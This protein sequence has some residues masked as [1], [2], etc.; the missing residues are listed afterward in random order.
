[1]YLVP[2]EIIENKILLIRGQKIMIDKDLA[3]LYH[4]KTKVLNQAVK[5]NLSRFPKDFMFK[6]T[7]KEKAEVVTNCDHLKELKYSYQKPY[8]FT[9]YGALM[10][11]NILNTTIAVKV[12]IQIVRT[13]VKLRKM[14]SSNKEIK[15]KIEELES[16]YDHQFKVVF[17]VI[18]KLLEPETKPKTQIGF[19]KST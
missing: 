16:K 13:F 7:E 15:Q 5:R 14:L 18:K 17:D 12:S 4:V 10:L 11:A 19:I 1:M 3:A 8:V 6:L 9:E 2:I